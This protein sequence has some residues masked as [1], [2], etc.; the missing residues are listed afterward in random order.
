MNRSRILKIGGGLATVLAATS[1][2]LATAAPA[3]ADADTSV[4]SVRVMYPDL[5]LATPKGTKLLFMRLKSAA[6]DVCGDLYNIEFLSEIHKIEQCQQTAMESA[7]MQVDRPLLTALYDRRYPHAPVV[8][9][10]VSVK[11]SGTQG[12]EVAR[13]G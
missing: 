11:P 12:L 1:L 13:R 7:V 10:R 9:V 6:Q 8:D 5:D 3:F 4:E 2:G